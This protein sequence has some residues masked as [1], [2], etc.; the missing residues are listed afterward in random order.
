MFYFPEKKHYL[1]PSLLKVSFKEVFFQA[2]DGTELHGWFFPARGKVKGS[3]TQFHGNAQNISTHFLSLLWVIEHGY[4]FFTFDY[5]GYGKSQGSPTPAGTHLDALAALSRAYELHQQSGSGKFV[6]YGQSLGGVIALRA[7]PEWENFSTTDLIVLDSTFSS[8]EKIALDKMKS[9][10]FLLPF[11]PLARLMKNE[12]DS[13]KV[14][15]KV[16]PPT[17]VIVGEKDQIV[18]AR[19]GLEIFEKINP[20]RKWLWRLPEGVHLNVFHHAQGE[21]RKRFL[22]LLSE[23]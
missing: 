19:F 1:E 12:Y 8:Y 5:R 15:S 9:S 14:F 21:Y 20:S 13:E 22:E 3:I 6:V 23:L 7:L 11:T 18:P 4:N 16:T 10:F 2:S 17:L